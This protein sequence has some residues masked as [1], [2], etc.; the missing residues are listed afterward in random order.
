M[1][2]LACPGAAAAELFFC[3]V[4]RIGGPVRDRLATKA[5][6]GLPARRP[7]FGKFN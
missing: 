3:G 6:R 1:G 4:K 7:V 5:R 2:R